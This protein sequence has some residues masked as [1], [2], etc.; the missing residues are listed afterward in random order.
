MIQ[1]DKIIKALQITCADGFIREDAADILPDIK[2]SHRCIISKDLLIKDVHFRA[3]YPSLLY[4]AHKALRVNLRDIVAVGAERARGGGS[5]LSNLMRPC[6]WL[7]KDVRIMG[8][9]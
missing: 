5:I 3:Q 9:L 2:A 4:L 7:W 1:E 8:C 6:K